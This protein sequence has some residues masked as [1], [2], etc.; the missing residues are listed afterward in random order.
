MEKEM[1]L[2][3]GRPQNTCVRCGV[4]IGDSGQHPSVIVA[5]GGNISDEDEAAIRQDYCPTCWEQMRDQDY[6]GFWL[7]KREK[8]KVLRLQSRKERNAAL[9]SYFDFLYQKGDPEFAQHVFFVSHLL[10]KFGVL[11][12]VRTEPPATTGAREQIVFRNT[13]TDDFV[14]IESVVLEE[15]RLASIKTEVDE[16]L[17]TYEA[18]DPSAQPAEGDVAAAPEP[19]PEVDVPDTS[20]ASSASDEAGPTPAT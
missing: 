12:W 19:G 1:Y 17:H 14:T 11:K 10:M 16:Y 5:T 6:I 8:P 13:V 20:D 7:A 2:K 15:D 4:K 18:P 9:L 3:I